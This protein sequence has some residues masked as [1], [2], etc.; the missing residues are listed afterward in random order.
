MSGNVENIDPETDAL[1]GMFKEH[2]EALSAIERVRDLH[3][4]VPCTEEGECCQICDYCGVVYPCPTIKA[5]DGE[6]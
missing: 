2:D 1:T 5:L 3:E 4:E 6:Q